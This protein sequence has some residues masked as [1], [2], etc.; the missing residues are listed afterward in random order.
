MV[1]RLELSGAIG[2]K[3]A[4]DWESGTLKL[5]INF[6]GNVIRVHMAMAD[7][8]LA[9]AYASI[10]RGDEATV[11]GA[12]TGSIHG[13]YCIADKIVTKSGWKH[14]NPAKVS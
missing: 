9:V 10:V 14:E 1:N 11:T 3:P 13:I 8:D 2:A 6:Y 12:V 4:I 5:V 7:D